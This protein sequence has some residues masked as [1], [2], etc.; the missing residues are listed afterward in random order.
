MRAVQFSHKPARININLSGAGNILKEVGG[1][2]LG[3]LAAIDRASVTKMHL[4]S[5]RCG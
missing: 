4:L 2:Q 3:R 5:L 1:R